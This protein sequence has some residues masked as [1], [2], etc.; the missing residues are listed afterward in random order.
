MSEI[1]TE[2]LNTL[3]NNQSLEGMKQLNINELDLITVLIGT[4]LGLELA[5]LTP[6]NEKIAQLNKLNGTI[7]LMK[8]ELK[9]IESK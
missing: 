7:I 9:S 5:S 4:C 1:K 2:Y 6:D 3:I 8:T